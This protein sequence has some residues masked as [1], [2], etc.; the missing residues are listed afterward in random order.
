MSRITI[1]LVL[2]LGLL[3]AG[4]MHH[5]RFHFTGPFPPVNEPK[6][7]VCNAQLVCR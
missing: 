7:P 2:W 4:A 3:G 5:Q 6:P 1:D